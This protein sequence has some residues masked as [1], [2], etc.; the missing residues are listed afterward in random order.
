MSLGWHACGWVVGSGG[1]RVPQ[2]YEIQIA[3]I[4]A[5][6]ELPIGKFRR[7]GLAVNVGATWLAMKRAGESGDKAAEEALSNVIL[8]WPFDFTF[9]G[10]DPEAQI[11]KQIINTPAAMERLREAI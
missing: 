5:A 9:D 7:M 2:G 10:T 6:T 4:T 3:L 1:A 8:D 11:M